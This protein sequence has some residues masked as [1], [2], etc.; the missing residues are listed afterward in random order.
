MRLARDLASLR[1]H[2]DTNPYA[3]PLQLTAWEWLGLAFV[4]YW[5]ISILACLGILTRR[6]YRLGALLTSLFALICLGSVAIS[7]Y[8]NT[9]N[10]TPYAVLNAQ[11]PWRFAPHTNTD[12]QS[13]LLP[14]GHIVKVLEA[15]DEW[16]RVEINENTTWV[17]RSAL[18]PVKTPGP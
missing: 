2:S 14:A 3:L 1:P 13:Q 5:I 6:P 10:C 17:E 4:T 11:S 15:H 12:A 16:V 18:S 7:Y 8:G 9:R